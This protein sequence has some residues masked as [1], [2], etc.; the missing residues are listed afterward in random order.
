MFQAVGS[1][2]TVAVRAG[3]PASEIEA[4]R[5]L[6]PLPVY[7]KV[8]LLPAGSVVEVSVPVVPFH[9]SMVWFPNRSAT[10]VRRPLE[11]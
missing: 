11:S 8:M 3:L 10:D 7:A 9:V 4:R 2:A 1:I 6:E 5:K